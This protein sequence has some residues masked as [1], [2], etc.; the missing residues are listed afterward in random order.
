MREVRSQTVLNIRVQG[1][2]DAACATLDALPQVQSVETAKDTL[3]VRL[4]EG[5]D[6]YSGL[7]SELV[8]AGHK[9]VMFKEEALNLET[10]FMTLTKG[11]TS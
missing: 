8:Q 3:I 6:D 11:I 1:D 4:N 7:A 2:L 9:I 5:V 10:A